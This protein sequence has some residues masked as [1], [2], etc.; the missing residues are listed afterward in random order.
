MAAYLDRDRAQALMAEAG[1]DA[2]VLFSAESFSYA[3]GAMSGVATM[4]RAAGAVAVMVP[5]DAG[6]EET[7]IVS[8][9]FLDTF[10][11]NSHITDIRE[12]AIWVETTAITLAPD[13]TNAVDEVAAAW[14]E[15]GRQPGFERPSTFDAKVCYQHLHDALAERGL[16]GKR[17][18]FEGEA[19]SVTDFSLLKNTLSNVQL[20]DA[21]DV[22]R[23]LKMVKCEREITNL[24]QAV[25]L[26]E[27]GIVAVQQAI[28]PGITRDGLAAV[29]Q[30]AISEHRAGINLTGEW[31][32]ISV[33]TDPW[34][35]NAAAQPGDLIKVDVGCLVDGY[36]SD[37]G[38]T[39]VLGQA[40]AAVQHIFNALLSGFEAGAKTIAPGV[41]MSEVHAATLAA[42]R[43][44][45]Y[46]GYT[47]GHFGHG[48]G[49]SLGS[50]QWPFFAAGSDVVLQPGM[51][52]AFECPWY[53]NGVGGMIVENQLLITESGHEMM[54]SLPLGLVSV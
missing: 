24:R 36:T 2:L 45:G 33:G 31:E 48:L 25:T 16:A 14:N 38:R 44:S 37:T 17:I 19:V 53:I 40:G 10:R 26:A 1:L 21:T 32:Y 3:T 4:W 13:A 39:F 47:R 51:V 46:A 11:K 20:V 12:S 41:P 7:A 49:A 50:E 34:G 18:G 22:V 15:A 28:S 35:G 6:V 30:S 5:A 29:W 9:L 43:S 27:R 52:L 42:I 8:D 23:R 54:N